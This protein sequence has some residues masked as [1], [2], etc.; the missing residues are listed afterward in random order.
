MIQKSLIILKSNLKSSP[1]KSF[2]LFI[3]E[4]NKALCGEE[5]IDLLSKMLVYDQN[6]R[7]SAK[8]ALNHP[9]FDP[10]KKMF[11]K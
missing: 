6:E 2:S 8:E 4:N 7:I 10:V 1:K 11:N 9:Y 3:N 5:A